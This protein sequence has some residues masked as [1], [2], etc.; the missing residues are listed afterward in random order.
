MESAI[1]TLISAVAGFLAAS[2]GFWVYLRNRDLKKDA[3]A[4]LLMG[5]AQYRIMT[6]G[7]RYLDRGWIS[8]D[9]YEDLRNYF[10]EPYAALGG[11]GT[12]ERVMDAVKLLPLRPNKILQ[13][14]A[15]ELKDVVRRES[16]IQ[17]D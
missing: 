6:L 7:M 16:E 10:Y 13:T 1:Q 5:L 17:R 11:N 4:R 9:E 2:G 8:T 12:A 14:P 3:N 15:S